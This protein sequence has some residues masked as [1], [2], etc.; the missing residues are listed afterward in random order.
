MKIYTVGHS[1]QSVDSFYQ[2]LS[3]IKVDCVIDVRSFPYSKYVPQ[4]D[5]AN[6]AQFLKQEGILYAHFGREFGARRN[7]CL[8]RIEVIKNREVVVKQQVDFEKG[9]KTVDFLNGVARL[10]NALSQGFQVALMCS[11]ENPLECHRFAFIARYMFEQGID[12]EHVIQDQ[13]HLDLL[14]HQE[15]EQM[16]ILDYVSKGK[17]QA[18]PGQGEPMLFYKE[19]S[20]Q[21]QRID[22][23]RLKNQEIGYCLD[24]KNVEE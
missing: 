20:K 18:L 3:K 22:A 5:K 11:E 8:K 4:F 14:S 24:D 21:Q 7:D 13:G 16:M 9:V 23:Y 15:L 17:L 12:V 1:N 6:L 10:I 19:Y 2:V